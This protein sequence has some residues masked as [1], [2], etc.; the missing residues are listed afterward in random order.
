MESYGDQEAPSSN[1]FFLQILGKSQA[2]NSNVVM[3][4][5]QGQT[6]VNWFL[7]KDNQLYG[8][9]ARVSYKFF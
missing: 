5:W 1:D 7:A 2:R 8:K 9:C 6:E 4:N 3:Y